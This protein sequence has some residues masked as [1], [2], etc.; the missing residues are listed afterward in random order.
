MLQL[1]WPSNFG[2]Q[3]AKPLFPTQTRAIDY[4]DQ[5]LRVL[6]DAAQMSPFLKPYLLSYKYKLK[7]IPLY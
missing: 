2:P 4:P 3:P 1:Y 5:L 6:E 7:M